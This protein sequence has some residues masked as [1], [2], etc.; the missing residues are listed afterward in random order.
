MDFCDACDSLLQ[1]KKV[2]NDILPYC[3]ECDEIKAEGKIGKISYEDEDRKADPE[4]GKMLIL[5]EQ[6]QGTVGRPQKEMFC[7]KCNTMQMI[8][9]WEIQTRSADEAPTRFFKCLGCEK[10]WREY[11]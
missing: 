2:D 4:G 3:I 9:F 8:E 6:Q 5:E 10:N 7:P 11:D 1:P